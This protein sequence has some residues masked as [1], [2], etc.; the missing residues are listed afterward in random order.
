MLH[1]ALQ[2]HVNQSVYYSNAV[3]SVS[4]LLSI[5]KTVVTGIYHSVARQSAH[6]CKGSA[7]SQWSRTNFGPLALNLHGN[8]VADLSLLCD[9]T[10][11]H[12]P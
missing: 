12:A 8:D 2:F 3:D 1:T 9:G 11:K 4:G 5:L 10:V 7:P 6:C